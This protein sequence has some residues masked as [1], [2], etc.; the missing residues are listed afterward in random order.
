MFAMV[1]MVL[2]FTTEY[3]RWK[4]AKRKAERLAKR[5]AEREANK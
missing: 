2:V 3:P 5:K 4:R 1:F